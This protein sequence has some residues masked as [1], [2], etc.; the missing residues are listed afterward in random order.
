MAKDRQPVRVRIGALRPRQLGVRR[1]PPGEARPAAL[2]WPAWI[3]L[4]ERH[5]RNLA[6]GN[7]AF[8]PP[9]AEYFVAATCSSFAL[10]GIDCTDQEVIDA[11]T[12]GFAQ[13]KFRSRASQ[14]VRN[15]VAILHSIEK[16][17]ELNYPLKSAAV[18]RWYTS[19][20]SGLS[21]SALGHDKM[22]RL[23]QI[24]GRINSPQLRLQPAIQEVARTYGELLADPLFPSF[25]GLL[26]RLL[27]R[28]HL[29]RCGLPGIV[30]EDAQGQAHWQKGD[31]GS[32]ALLQAI[33]LSYQG[34]LSDQGTD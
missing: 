13:R 22:A 26:A 1:R 34:L 28:F 32:L 31:T 9:L 18:L 24:I 10:E 2:D 25:N 4:I 17:L 21:P 6:R 11:I 16:S 3:A 8:H 20:G 27:L 23:E 19:I 14:R 7:G 29:G 33:E 30:F 5:R 12:Q 15:H